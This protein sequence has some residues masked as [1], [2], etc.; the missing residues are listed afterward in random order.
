MDNS[1]TS[2][3]EVF[4]WV[5]LDSY[6]SSYKAGVWKRS[7]TLWKWIPTPENSPPSARA[8]DLNSNMSQ[9]DNSI[10]VSGNV[11]VWSC[12]LLK[13]FY[14]ET[15]PISNLQC[16]NFVLHVY[17][18]YKYQSQK[19]AFY[20]SPIDS[21]VKMTPPTPFRNFYENSRF[22][23]NWSLWMLQIAFTLNDSSCWI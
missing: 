19:V 1:I 16:Y 3:K 4:V 2:S 13:R 10:S 23:K 8:I 14:I 7:W 20:H 17:Y 11:F 5:Q 9:L 15:H 18:K 12:L 21:S 6:H 22:T